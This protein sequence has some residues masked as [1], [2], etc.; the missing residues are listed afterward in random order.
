MKTNYL[1]FEQ[2]VAE[3]EEKIE[4]LRHAGASEILVSALDKLLL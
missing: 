3:L 2:P 4:Q 1:N